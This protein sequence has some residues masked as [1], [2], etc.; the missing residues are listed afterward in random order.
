MEA[1]DTVM[2]DEQIWAIDDTIDLHKDDG[3][4]WWI[5]RHHLKAQ[6]EISYKAGMKEVV[7]WINTHW[8][9]RANYPE[10]QAFLKEDRDMIREQM[11]DLQ[12]KLDVGWVANCPV[13]IKQQGE[14]AIADWK[15]DQL[16]IVLCAEIEKMGLSDEEQI[17]LDNRFRVE[18]DHRLII[19][20]VAQAQLQKILK[21][22][23]EGAE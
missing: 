11:A 8:W 9:D 19:R 21:E 14:K 17:T 22:L 3:K 16:I 6:A 5:E 10:W 15:T 7:E 13:K 12:L 2:S 18:T 1:K 20:Q 4:D 23:K